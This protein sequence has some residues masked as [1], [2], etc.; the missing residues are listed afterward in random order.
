MWVVSAVWTMYAKR[1]G[2]S[3]VSSASAVRNVASV[4]AARGVHNVDR[5]IGAGI[6]RNVARMR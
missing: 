2:V 4:G 1:D 5:I 6:V 3:V